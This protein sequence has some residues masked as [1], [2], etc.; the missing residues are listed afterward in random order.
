METIANMLIIRKLSE[1]Y[2]FS[3]KKARK[4]TEDCRNIQTRTIVKITHLHGTIFTLIKYV[5][6]P[7]YIVACGGNGKKAHS[8]YLSIAT[9]PYTL[10]EWTFTWPARQWKARS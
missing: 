8:D 2:P 6:K 9:A 1:I 3:F 7:I 4:G 10:Q 5:K